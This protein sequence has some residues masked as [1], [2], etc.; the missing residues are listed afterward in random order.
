MLELGNIVTEGCLNVAPAPTA[1]NPS[2][3]DPSYALA[4]PTICGTNLQTLILKPSMAICCLLGSVQLTAIVVQNGVETDVTAQTVFTTTDPDIAVVGASSGNV[5]GLAG[6]DVVINASYVNLTATCSLTVIGEQHCCDTI[7]VAFMVLVDDSKSMSQPF[8]GAY[9]SKLVFAKAAASQFIASVNANK[10]SV[11]LMSFDDSFAPVLSAPSSNIA[12]VGALVAGISQSQQLTGYNAALTAAITALNATSATE[13]IIVLISDGEDTSVNDPTD[14]ADAINTIN[15]FKASGGIVIC[16]GVRAS[17][18]NFLFLEALATGGFFI[19]AYDATAVSSLQYLLGLKGYICAGNCTPPGDE[20]EAI[21]QLDYCKFAN[22]NVVDGHVDLIGNGFLDFLPGNGLYVDL[23][24]STAPHGGEMISKNTFGLL[25]GKTYRLSLEL[26]GNQRINVTPNTVNFAVFS[27][28]TDIITNPS[29]A[30]V[31]TVNNSGASLSTTPTYKYAYTYINANGETIASPVTSATPTTA[32]ASMVVQCTANGAASNIKIYRTSGSTPDSAFYEIAEIANTA[33]AYTDYMN[34]ADFQAA[35]VAGT[36]DPCSIAPTS[37]TTGTPVYYLNQSVT[38]NNYQQGFEPQSFTF[39]VPANVNVWVSIQ[40]TGIPSAASAAGLLLDQVSLDNV[41]DMVNLLSD[42]FDA[43]NEEYIP[44]ACGVGTTYVESSGTAALIP[45]M[46]S[47]TAPSGYVASAS[48]NSFYAPEPWLGS[49]FGA[50]SQVN[51][52][53][54]D[55]TTGYWGSEAFAALPQ[56][57]QIQLPVAQTVGTYQFY[58]SPA[59]GNSPSTWTFA[60]SNDGLTWTTLDTQSAITWGMAGIKSF[61]IAHP[62]SFLYY[63]LTATVSQYGDGVQILCFQMFSVGSG[64]YITGYNCY[65]SG[66]LNVPP[67]IQVQDPN[68]LPSI[69]AAATTPTQYTSTQTVC[70]NC[71]AG[72]S[73]LVVPTGLTFDCA[74]VGGNF[75]C[76]F[77]LASAVVLNA[78]SLQPLVSGAGPSGWQFQG[79]ND[80][81]TWTTLDTESGIV[82]SGTTTQQ[83]AFDNTTSYLYYRI[84]FTAPVQL[85]YEI[86][87]VGGTQVCATASAASL[88]SQAVADNQATTSATTQAMKLLNCAPSWTATESYTASCPVGT[89]GQSVTQSATYTSFISLLDAQ[90]QAT[91]LAQAAAIAM[92]SCNSSNNGQQI[93]INDDAAASPY[94]SVQFVSGLTGVITKVTVSLVGLTH[95]SPSDVEIVLRSPTGQTCLLMW[96]CGSPGHN[97]TNI[98]L[99]FDD[100]AATNLPSSGTIAGGSF[101]PSEYGAIAN[102]PA[103]LPAPPYGSTLAAFVGENPNGSWALFVADQVPLDAGTLASWSVTITSA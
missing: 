9:A 33:P 26:A 103:P 7:P 28:N 14:S 18:T 45:A 77:T 15:S 17:G 97:V 38:L 51:C 85:S 12:A 74:T 78:Y 13:K 83:F 96:N 61:T 70:V 8:N 80:N 25:A 81:S 43:E 57:L 89:L 29:V 58:G 34:L 100:A 62:Q 98:N 16:L 37:N 93:V 82:W 24:G 44:P 87:T 35:L 42:N 92:L 19:N 102:M 64:G 53:S 31:V 47:N 91:A 86:F 68:P 69:E 23:A 30:P 48:T 66:C 49:P 32:G 65:G 90:T 79:S 67:A 59:V 27:R 46:T 55:G 4:N 63:R 1:A 94:P 95:G 99:T 11:G 40:Q 6:G 71:P 84:V 54:P 52:S 10:D 75:I 60:G 20:Y 21:G 56:W 72:T 101:R 41:T 36:I 3:S 2:C 5:T 76:T 50:F 22:W 88:I 73:S 39:T